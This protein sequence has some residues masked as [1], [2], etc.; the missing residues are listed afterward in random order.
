MVRGSLL[1]AGLLAFPAWTFAAI[2]KWVDEN[3][4]TVYSNQP[5]ANARLARQATVVVPD[6]P[7]GEAA[8]REESAR[9]ELL[10]RIARL[11]RQLAAQQYAPPVQY[12]PPVQYVPAM[13]PPSDYY[14]PPVYPAAVV[15]RPARFFARHV[16]ARQFHHHHVRR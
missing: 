15:V 4:T 2:Y 1:V 6:E 11:E 8:A 3:G 5:P 16:S 9:R 12:T 10:E 13:A 14:Y 7:P